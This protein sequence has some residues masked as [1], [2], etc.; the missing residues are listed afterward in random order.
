MLNKFFLTVFFCLLF[1]SLIA[2]ETSSVLMHESLKAQNTGMLFLGGWAITNL[3]V[4]G[5][6]WAHATGHWKYFHQMN[7]MWNVVNLS[8][9]GYALYSNSST[10]WETIHASEFLA[11]HLNTERILLINSALDLG[12]IGTGF[13]LKHFSYRSANHSNLLKGYGNALILQGAFLLVFDLSLY[14]V[15]HHKRLT[16]G[17][18][19]GVVGLS[20][21]YAL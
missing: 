21:G 13:L 4:G 18:G 16:L 19:P 3:V 12:Y 9:A 7:F 17:P 6:G 15:L 20:I 5:Y 10:H 1:N 14:Q 8:I 2:Q 11:S